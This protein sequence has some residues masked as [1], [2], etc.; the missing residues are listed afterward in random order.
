MGLKGGTLFMSNTTDITNATWKIYKL[1]G[2]TG[3]V[4]I[5]C[6][7]LDLEQRWQG[8]RAYKANSELFNDILTY[9]WN[10]FR[11]EIIAEYKAEKDAREREHVEIQNYNDGYNIYRGVKKRVSTNGRTPSKPVKCIE[12]GIIYASIKEAARQ[13]GLAKNKISYC[14]RGIRKRTGG[15]HWKFIN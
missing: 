10:A 5:G 8:G 7:K 14:C 11:K 13:T 2:P 4:Y 12:T 1:T 9:G 15:Y 3:R 6:T